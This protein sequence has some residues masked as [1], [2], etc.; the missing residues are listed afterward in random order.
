MALTLLEFAKTIQDTLLRGVIETFV[1]ASDVLR[2]LPFEII[3]GN[4]L[5]YNKEDALPGIAF[6]GL[7]EAYT[8]SVGVVLPETEKLKIMGGDADSDLAYRKW[9]KGFD[10]HAYDVSAKAKAAALYFNKM[11]FD[12]DESTDP[13]QFYGLN[14]RLTGN[15]IIYAGTDGA[16]LSE[17]LLN[18]LIDAI[19]SQPDVLL[20]GKKTRRQ[21]NNLAKSSTILTI[22]KDEFGQA[23][24]MYA[25]IP[26]G[27]IDKDNSGNIIL[28]FD[29]TR[30]T[31]NVTASIYAVKFGFFQYLSG[32]QSA[33]IEVRPLGEIDAKSAERT[34][35]EW[36]MGIAMFH[37]RSAARLAGITAA[38]A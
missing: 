7:N 32:I 19:D 18:Q 31:S 9:A 28:D 4:A 27:I 26:I 12:G 2:Y 29:E 38:V 33:P 15:Q 1:G 17:A 16:A 20:M 6:R 3:D 21:I 36:L 8:E 30:G 23:Y 34:R 22:G 25:G 13:R 5:S 24:E 11:F 14:K 10:R 37:P 35:I